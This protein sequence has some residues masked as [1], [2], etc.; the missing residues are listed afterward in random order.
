MLQRGF[1]SPAD[2]DLFFERLRA[3]VNW[4]HDQIRLYGKTMDL[5]R[6]H[7][8]FGDEHKTYVWSG[9][10]MSPCPWTPLIA[11]LKNRVELQTGAR[12]NSVLANLYRDG[13]DS[14]SWHSD[15]ERELGE[16]PTIASLSLGAE[17]EF[18]FRAKDKHSETTKV[19][20]PHGS[21]LFMYGATQ[22]LT[23]HCLPKSSRV[24]N[25][26]VNLTFRWIA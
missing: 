12:F 8:W 11:E 13:H 3:E 6:L 18:F 1:L 7:Q 4:R 14:V 24:K 20:L 17:R 26:R 23:E 21:L 5:P 10:Q 9:I 15:D 22:A 25:A 19:V 16:D 2:A